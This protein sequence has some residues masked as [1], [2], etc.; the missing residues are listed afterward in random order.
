VAQVSASVRLN[1][2][3]E[4]GALEFP[5]HRFT[6]AEVPVGALLAWPSFVT[7]PHRSAP[8]R[9]GVKYSLTIWFELPDQ[10]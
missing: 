2:G 6:N 3:Y 1:D 8:V 4:G 10:H 7:H 5:R 9:H